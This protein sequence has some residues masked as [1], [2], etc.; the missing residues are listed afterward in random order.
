[1][2]ANTGRLRTWECPIFVTTQA[3]SILVLTDKRKVRCG[4]IKFGVQPLGRLVTSCAIGAHGFF[5]RQDVPVAIH[6]VRRRFTILLVCC[7]A[8]GTFG[9]QVRTGQVE[10]GE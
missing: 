10:I 8:V 1:M 7:M 9:L 6:A 2:A 3:L 4:V 5:V